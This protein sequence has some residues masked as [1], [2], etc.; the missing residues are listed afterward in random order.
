MYIVEYNTSYCKD[1]LW[2]LVH[3]Y[4]EYQAYE[5]LLE[6]IDDVSEVRSVLKQ[7]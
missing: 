1:I 2:V 5:K 3:A 6:L 7:F 4:S